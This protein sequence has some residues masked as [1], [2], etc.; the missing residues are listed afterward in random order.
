MLVRLIIPINIPVPFGLTHSIRTVSETE[1]TDITKKINFNSNNFVFKTRDNRSLL[2][3][4][5]ASKHSKPNFPVII[6]ILWFSMVVF[7]GSGTLLWN[8]R[9]RKTIRGFLPVERR[10]ITDF[11]EIKRIELNLKNKIEILRMNEDMP[12]GPTVVGLRN[13]KILLPYKMV[14][15]WPIEDIEPLIVHEL[16][17][18][19]R[20]D[21]YINWVQ[22]IIQILYFF[23]PCVWFATWKIRDIREQVCDDI[24]IQ[25]I[26]NKRR[27]YSMSII[28]VIEIIFSEPMWVYSDIGFSERKSSL[29][30]RII[31]ISNQKYSFHKPLNLL[32]NILLVITV[33]LSVTLACDYAPEKILGNESIGVPKISQETADEFNDNH[34]TIL[35]SETGDYQIEGI[36]TNY[37][38]LKNTLQE[39]IKKYSLKKV[40]I[41]PNP[42]TPDK[43]V[44]YAVEVSKNLKITKIA[45]KN[46]SEW[47]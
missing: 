8:L 37:L 28:N 43:Y 35:I 45:V 47:R 6:S 23:N 29:A 27:R 12:I 19:K 42:Q 25:Y 5:L 10:D 33:V 9:V 16:V 38:N 40:M 21:L 30:K 11:L 22:I 3:S 34:I 4:V 18:I 15:K 31:R 1:I 13:P 14:E 41:I 7:L 24:A 39:T 32:S 36:P 26:E 44:S 17:H 46:T 20:G 2:S